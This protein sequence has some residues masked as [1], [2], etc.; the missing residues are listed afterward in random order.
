[1][2]VVVVIDMDIDTITTTI[3]DTAIPSLCIITE[4]NRAFAAFLFVWSVTM[5]SIALGGDTAN[6]TEICQ[7]SPTGMDQA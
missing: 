6:H 4:R 2:V 5:Y 7:L 1:M 3:I